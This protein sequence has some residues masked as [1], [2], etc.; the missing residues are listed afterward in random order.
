MAG[1]RA[2]DGVDVDTHLTVLATLTILGGLGALAAG[3]FAAWGIWFGTRFALPEVWPL[4]P[5]GA[6]A[7]LASLVL[8]VALG[9]AA[10]ALAGG[11]GLV[12]RSEWG[13]VLTLVAAGGV[14]L[15]ALASFTL[16]PLA[17]T[18]YAA[19]VLTRPEVADAFKH[20]AQP[21]DLADA[22]AADPPPG[23]R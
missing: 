2:G 20:R 5:T 1:P 19:W 13:R 17:Y 18:A 22:D 12:R 7:W 15:V 21:A 11:I 4:V 3:L 10:V 14:G 6:F 16:L 23:A 9:A 8:A